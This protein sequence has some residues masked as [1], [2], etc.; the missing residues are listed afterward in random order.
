VLP[1]VFLCARCGLI[2]GAAKRSLVNI[3]CWRRERLLVA[4]PQQEKYQR[5]AGL[6]EL[7]SLWPMPTASCTNAYS[8]PIRPL[9]PFHFGH[10]FQFISATG[11]G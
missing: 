7:G 4:H 1:M 5:L 2:V 3:R 8:G 6:T 11:S 9:I 10:R